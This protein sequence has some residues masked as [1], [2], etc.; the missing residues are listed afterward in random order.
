M[1]NVWIARL[2]VHAPSPL[3]ADQKNGA[4]FPRFFFCRG[5]ESRLR[6]YVGHGLPDTC[7]FRTSTHLLHV[8]NFEGFEWLYLVQ[9]WPDKHQ[10]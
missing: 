7:T 1:R 2:C 3:P 6:L 9:Y 4:A 8:V 5:F 10:T